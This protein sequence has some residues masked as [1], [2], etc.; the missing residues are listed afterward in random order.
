VTF[1]WGGVSQ[2]F[3]KMAATNHKWDVDLDSIVFEEDR[4]LRKRYHVFMKKNR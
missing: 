4:V 3:W 2:E 1:D